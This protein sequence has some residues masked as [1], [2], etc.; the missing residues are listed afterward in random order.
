MKLVI[1]ISILI[2]VSTI[3][4]QGYSQ[5]LNYRLG[6]NF[7]T[8][9]SNID[10]DYGDEPETK[11]KLGLQLGFGFDITLS[12]KLDIQPSLLYS[13]KGYNEDIEAVLEDI[14]YQI[15]DF[16]G[17][18]RINYTYIELPVNLVYKESCFRFFGGPYFAFGIKGSLKTDWS[19]KINGIDY[20]SEYFFDENEYS[21][22]PVYG[23]VD[24]DAWEESYKSDDPIDFFRG[25]D[26]GLN[27]GVGYRINDIQVNISYSHGL[28]NL[29]P[30]YDVYYELDEYTYISRDE[31]YNNNVI[32]KNRVLNLSLVLYME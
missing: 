7:S 18:H 15:T 22:K 23:T 12:E 17:Y 6:G 21:I 4:L 5:K 29:T 32:L 26:Y 13:N 30:E 20:D 25:F 2:C 1:K 24:T 8:I 3:A 16:D 10:S 19:C 31:E 11:R 9:F 14:G 28:A 27:I